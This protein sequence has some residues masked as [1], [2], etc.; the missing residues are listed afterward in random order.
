MQCQFL[1]LI[2]GCVPECQYCS[3]LDSFHHIGTKSSSTIAVHLNL[4][5]PSSEVSHASN[6]PSL[7]R[8]LAVMDSSDPDPDPHFSIYAELLP[9]LRQLSV[10]ITLPS[11]NDATTKVTVTNDAP[12]GAPPRTALHV[13]H[14]G[15]S[16]AVLIPARV[17][18]PP[19]MR[20]PADSPPATLLQFRLALAAGGGG[21][22]GVGVG[23]VVPWEAADLGEGAAVRCRV[24]EGVVVPRA[25]VRAWKDL[26]SENW[27]EMMEFWH[28]HKPGHHGHGLDDEVEASKAGDDELAS[29]GYGASSIVTAQRGV[30]LVDL[31]A[32]LFA[33]EDCEAVVVSSRPC[34][35]P[36]CEQ[37]RS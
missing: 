30:G 28:C 35:S 3:I 33:E 26:P 4:F 15:A 11:P 22:G 24:C 17:A 8:F 31:T 7:P 10:A 32:I 1:E 18:A 23:A 36:S 6:L 16:R 34:S 2:R 21:G 9:N 29:R 37:N 5:P 14:R 27:A 19:V 20:L 13:S 12:D 25:R